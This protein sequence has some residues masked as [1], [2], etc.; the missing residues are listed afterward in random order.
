MR[1]HIRSF[2]THLLHVGFVFCQALL[3]LPVDLIADCL[4][5][6]V[7]DEGLGYRILVTAVHQVV[8]SVLFAILLNL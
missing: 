2:Q 1:K 7:E 3:H 4:L 8:V 5:V 6:V